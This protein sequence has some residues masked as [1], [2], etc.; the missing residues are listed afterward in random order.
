ML[1]YKVCE[2]SASCREWRTIEGFSGKVMS[3]G[4]H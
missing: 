3:L 4:P 2:C 1:N